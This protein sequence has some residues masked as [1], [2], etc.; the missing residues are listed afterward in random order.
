LHHRRR[1]QF[2]EPLH[3]GRILSGA[4]FEFVLLVRLEPNGLAHERVNAL[5]QHCRQHLRLEG[6][7]SIVRRGVRILG[8]LP[9]PL[10]ARLGPR[11]IVL[12]FD[13]AVMLRAHHDRREQQGE[14]NRGCPAE[15]AVAQQPG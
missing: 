4:E 15:A 3:G 5:I 7:Y 10:I 13:L 12:S 2:A 11:Q 14:D 8:R 6:I 9:Q 1:R